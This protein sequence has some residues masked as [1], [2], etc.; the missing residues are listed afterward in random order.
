VTLD[1]SFIVANGVGRSLR[2]A[3]LLD[4][5]LDVVFVAD[6][7]GRSL[8]GAPLLDVALDVVFVVA[9]ALGRSLLTAFLGTRERVALD[10][11]LIAAGPLLC[12]AGLELVALDVI[13]LGRALRGA[14]AAQWTPH[15][16]LVLLIHFY[17]RVR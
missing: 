4:M 6:P 7:L 15:A 14:F 16:R 13:I 9:E 3:T 12:A 8:R 1:V 17:L 11:G 10:V 2:G 5:A